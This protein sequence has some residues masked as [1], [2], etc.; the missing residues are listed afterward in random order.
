MKMLTRAYIIWWSKL[1]SDNEQ[2]AKNCSNCQATSSSPSKA[3]LH[4]WEW[5][6]QL[7][8]R[9]HLDF[10]GTFLGNMYLVFVDAYSKWLNIQVMQ[11]ITD[12]RTSQKL[13]AIFATHEIPQKIV[14]D[15]GP[16]LRSE[17]F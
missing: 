5:P 4:P 8:S 10:A 12:V 13:H 7:W 1:D 11:S 3:P 17:Q 9:L 6:A 16:T 2:L 15:N 14:T